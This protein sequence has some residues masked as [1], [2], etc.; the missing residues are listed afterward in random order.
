MGRLS[1]EIRRLEKR[2]DDLAAANMS[3]QGHWSEERAREYYRL[4]E[5][6]WQ[7]EDLSDED[8]ED[9]ADLDEYGPIAIAVNCEDFYLDKTAAEY[10]ET[11]LPPEAA[12]ARRRRIEGRER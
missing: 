1:D 12:Q 11:H 2:L 4:M 9:V 10:A 6:W 3:S 8:P 5:R 7:G